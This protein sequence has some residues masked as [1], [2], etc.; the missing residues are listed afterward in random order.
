[1][2]LQTDPGLLNRR[3]TICQWRSVGDD[4]VGLNEEFTPVKT[5]WASVEPIRAL[6][7]WLGKLQLDTAATHRFVM[8]RINGVSRP[9]DLTGR[10]ALEFG[11]QYYQVLRAT[12]LEGA[13]RFT[14]VE[15]CLWGAQDED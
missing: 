15:A 12:D 14:A 10:H 9:E 6:T 7:Y 1:M 8:R 5:L 3:V 11:G 4:D 2:T 13:Q